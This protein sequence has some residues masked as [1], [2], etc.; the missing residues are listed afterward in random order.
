MGVDSAGR[1]AVPLDFQVLP[2]R[3]RAHGTTLVQENF[4]LAQDKGV[5]LKSGRVVRLKVPDV[6]PDVL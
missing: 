5:A 6:G 1:V 2:E 4:D 3:L